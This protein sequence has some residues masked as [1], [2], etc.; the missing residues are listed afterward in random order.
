MC[1]TQNCGIIRQIFG[2]MKQELLVNSNTERFNSLFAACLLPSDMNS[3]M[4][5]GL[6]ILLILENK[7]DT[8]VKFK[9]LE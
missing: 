2:H 3:V 9:V 4:F 5:D 6:F 1:V 7:N 8:D